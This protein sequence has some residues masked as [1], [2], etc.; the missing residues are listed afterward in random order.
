MN[1]A[2]IL[3]RIIH[4]GA[5][6]LWVGTGAMMILVMM[7][8][9]N[10]VGKDAGAFINGMMLYSIFPILTPVTAALTTLSGAALYILVS[11]VFNP[12]WMVLPSSIV[13][14]VG[15]VFGLLAFGH[16]SA[17]LGKY[18]TQQRVIAA[19]FEALEGPPSDAL[20]TRLNNNLAKMHLHSKI[21]FALMIVAVVTM[22]AHRY[23][24]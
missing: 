15:A 1:I 19:E 24:S 7:P 4:I 10:K 16:G 18:T 12:R 13:L 21:S 20:S 22:S 17:A 8:T 5:A 3:L 2:F 6:V 9:A 11:D 14:T 23:V